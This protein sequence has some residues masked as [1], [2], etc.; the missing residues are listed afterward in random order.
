[1]TT[2]AVEPGSADAEETFPYKRQ[3]PFTP[4]K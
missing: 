4:P 3:C 1:M 2:S